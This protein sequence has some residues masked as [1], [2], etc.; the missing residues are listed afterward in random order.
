M[1]T[2]DT[3]VKDIP[4]IGEKYAKKL[5]KL[6]IETIRDLLLHSPSRYL[7][8]S[9][10]AKIQD[11]RQ[12]ESFTVQ[13]QITSITNKRTWKRGLNITEAII[14]DDTD[15][16]K[17][18]WFNQPFIAHRLKEGQFVNFSGKIAIQNS[19]TSGTEAYFS[20][21]IYE[22]LGKTE[23]AHTGRIIPIYP[24]T[25]GLTSRWIRFLIK[26]ALKYTPQMPEIIPQEITRNIQPK[27]LILFF[28]PASFSCSRQS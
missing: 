13:G 5:K 12:G 20:N 15:S 14:K 22:P 27:T 1:I 23:L 8:F 26:N 16:I 9:N 3:P 6:G 18:I 7:D 24:E 4:R 28:P 19:K 10:I 25:A 2:L 21:P 17:A 11:V